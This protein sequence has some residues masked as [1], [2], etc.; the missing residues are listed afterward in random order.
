MAHPTPDTPQPDYSQS[1]RI[2]TLIS[3]GHALSNFYVLCI[4][5]LIPFLKVEFG[6]SYTM[7]GL[8]LTIRPITT[9]LLQIPMGFLVDH[10]GGKR[11]LIAGLFTLSVSFIL[12]SMVPSFWSAMP[13]M[14]LF[15]VGISTMRPSNYTILNASMSPN[16]IG[17][18]FGINMFAAHAGR[19]VAPPLIVFIALQWDWR[20]ALLIAGVMGLI[21]TA[22]LMTQWRIVRDDVVRVKRPEGLGF[23]Q[24]IRLLASGSL[25]LFLIFFIFNALTTHGIHSFV[26]AAL[27]DLHD[28]PLTMASSALTGYLVAS[29]IGVLAGGFLVDKTPRHTLIAVAVLAG[30]GTLFVMLGSVSMPMALIIAALSLA[31]VLQGILRPARDMLMRAVIPR[32]SFGK[33]IGMVATGAA[34]GGAT[35]PLLFGYI[36]DVGEAHWL[37]YVLAI[38]LAILIVT[39]MIPKRRI[40][41]S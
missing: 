29:A 2:L 32:E 18:A 16:W 40:E 35:A 36:L 9:G 20:V 17:R 33:A 27:V 38:C 19:A 34:I 3:S 1:V 8:L 28:A 37:F 24:E 14:M 41:L 23:F 12:F 13:V 4:P 39:I 30:S 21:V 22:T 11:M 6:V 10:L 7:L 5:V 15:G 31:G 26:V 25:F